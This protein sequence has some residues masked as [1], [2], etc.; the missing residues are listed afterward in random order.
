MYEWIWS[1]IM[2]CRSRQ[3]FMERYRVKTQPGFNCA[4]MLIYNK[5]KIPL[6]SLNLRDTALNVPQ[7]LTNHSVA[8]FNPWTHIVFRAHEEPPL[9]SQHGLRGKCVFGL[10]EFILLLPKDPHHLD[11]VRLPSELLHGFLPTIEEKKKSTENL[12]PK[13]HSRKYHILK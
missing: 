4:K 3:G 13:S 2:S 8:F 1:W 10:L 7:S 5:N 11:R 9:Q 6:I 12:Q